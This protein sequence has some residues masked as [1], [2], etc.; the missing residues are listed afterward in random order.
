MRLTGSAAGTQRLGESQRYR[1]YKQE[2]HDKEEKA[3]I[4]TREDSSGKPTWSSEASLADVVAHS[5]GNASACDQRSLDVRWTKRFHDN[6]GARQLDFHFTASLLRSTVC[7]W[8]KEVLIIQPTGRRGPKHCNCQV[9]ADC[10]VQ[11]L[12][13]AE[14]GFREREKNGFVRF[15]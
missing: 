2:H 5:I 13:V 11:K 8:T 1:R 15:I 7:S 4:R 6:A 14:I 9:L 12:V 10:S 3:H